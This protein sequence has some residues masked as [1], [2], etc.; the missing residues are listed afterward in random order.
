MR[1]NKCLLE[2]RKN[3]GRNPSYVPIRRE[4]K[5][6]YEKGKENNYMIGRKEFMLVLKS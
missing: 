5:G 6:F 1:G 3:S 4:G 2:I